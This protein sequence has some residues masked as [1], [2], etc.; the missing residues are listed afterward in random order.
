VARI[1]HAK[2][3]PSG[4]TPV[5]NPRHFRPAFGHVVRKSRSLA[6]QLKLNVGKARAAVLPSF[7]PNERTPPSWDLGKKRHEM[8]ALPLLERI[9]ERPAPRP[10]SLHLLTSIRKMV[11]LA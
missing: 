3:P 10:R 8:Y 7:Q 2:T 4:P 6:F 1:P 9:L 5:K 11:A